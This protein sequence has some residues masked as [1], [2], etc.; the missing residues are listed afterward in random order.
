M[1]G[2]QQE[3]GIT[4]ILD[5]D[6][7]ATRAVIEKIAPSNLGYP[8]NVPESLISTDIRDEFGFNNIE[9]F[10]KQKNSGLFLSKLE[11]LIYSVE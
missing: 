6:D 11:Q 2:R 7:P 9:A 8:I 10:A 3:E 4:Y 1:K 5:Q